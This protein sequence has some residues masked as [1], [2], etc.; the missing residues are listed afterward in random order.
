MPK[1]VDPDQKRAELVA[2]SWQVIATEGLRGATLRRVAAEA[3]CTTGALTHYFADRQALLT[4]A[5]QA[6]QR[7]TG[8]RMLEASRRELGDRQRLEAVLLEALPLDETRL[9]EWRVWLAFWGE[10]MCDPE[11]A[12]EDARRYDEWRTMLRSVVRPLVEDAKQVESEV[13]H[14]IALVDGLGLRV[15]RETK[16]ETERER[17]WAAVRKVLQQHLDRFAS[18]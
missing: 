17:D 2:A 6:A 5:L 9:E 3:G 4:A 16:S 8:L 13:E 11:L 18:S 1:I 12:A 15:A 10:S 7:Q 14:L